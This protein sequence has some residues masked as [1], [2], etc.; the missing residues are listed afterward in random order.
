MAQTL[1]VYYQNV[2]GLRTKTHE[3]YNKILANNYDVIVMVETW[4]CDGIFNSEFC[5]DRYDIFRIDRDLIATNKKIGGGVLICVR[6]ELK[7][8]CQSVPSSCAPTEI[9]WVSIPAQSL[10]SCGNLNIISTYIRG[11]DSSQQQDI[12]NLTT[13]L[14]LIFP[15]CAQ[16]HD[17]NKYLLLGDFNLPYVEWNVGIPTIFPRD[18]TSHT[19]DLVNNLFDFLS[20]HGLSQYNHNKNIYGNTLDLVFCNFEIELNISQFPLLKIDSAHPPLCIDASEITL[21]PIDGQSITKF[22]FHKGDYDNICKD[23]KNINWDLEFA[24]RNVNEAVEF[25]YEKLHFYINLYIPVITKNSKRR[26]Y[27]IWY[28]KSL[29]KIIHEKDKVHKKWKRFGN[30]L[31]YAEFSLL[32]NRYH[33]VHTACYNKYLFNCQQ[34]LTKNPKIFW[35]YAKSRKQ[36]SNYPNILTLNNRILSEGSDMVEGF[37]NF[38]YSMFSLPVP[39]Y[40]QSELVD[41]QQA[42]ENI[43]TLLISETS[44]LSL[45]KNL[46]VKKG[47]GCDNIPPYFIKQCASVLAGPLAKLFTKS[48]RGGVFPTVWKE[49]K[50]VPVHKKGLK[51]KIENYRPISILNV[52]SKIFEKSVYNS[53]YPFVSKCIPSE[54]HGF[55]KGRSTTTNLVLFAKYIRDNIEQGYQID[56]IYTDF[57]KAFDRVDHNILLSKLHKLGIHGD[58]LRWIESYLTNRCQAVVLGGYRSDFIII[59]SG[60]PQGSH[61]GPLFYNIYLYDIYA[62]LSYSKFLMYADDTK[63][64]L[65]ISSR[66]DSLRLQ[67]DLNQLCTYYRQ[68]R[69]SVNVDKCQVITFTRKQHP[70]VFSYHLNDVPLQRVDHIRD[71]GLHLDSKFTFN[72]HIDVIT[73]KAFKSLGFIMRI[74]APFRNRNCIKSVFF[75]YVRSVLEYGSN[76]W[77]PNYAVHIDRIEKIQKRFVKFLNFRTFTT[78]ST[79]ESNC[80]VH[81]MLPLHKR[82][83]LLDMMLLYNVINSKI[84][85]PELIAELGIRVPLRR[86]RHTKFLHTKFHRTNYGRNETLT[87]IAN[88]FNNNFNNLDPFVCTKN[89]FRKLVIQTL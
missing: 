47:A 75:A 12:L 39:Q 46:D 81:H 9:L 14:Q 85:C 73:N 71:L 69:I 10:H 28:T 2:R 72:R 11:V 74:C 45:L 8:Y 70:L 60:V 77:S 86:T 24:K 56:V 66:D 89:T 51:I 4:L 57:E 84:D 41:P 33:R 83:I 34:A 43:G 49:A 42:V 65:R 15:N 6:R 26:C 1:N 5:D 19:R 7:A 48:I 58:L 38:F 21:K 82:R 30:N 36:T 35:S 54:Q 53:I 68:N 64:F 80:E 27:P 16:A 29:I 62:A 40:A 61:L 52:F 25:L 78:P 37:N 31:D 63:I 22:A 44:V 50:I 18:S 59:P 87:R 23:L 79:Y 67:H 17:N 13:L 32:R 20:I 88:E 76:I 55:L 3:C